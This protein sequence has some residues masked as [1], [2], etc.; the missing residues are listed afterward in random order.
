MKRRDFLRTLGLSC[1]GACCNP[2][3][4]LA[5]GRATLENRAGYKT[6]FAPLR[7]NPLRTSTARITSLDDMTWEPGPLLQQYDERQQWRR[8]L[9][10][11]IFPENKRTSQLVLP[12]SKEKYLA[13]DTFESLPDTLACE[14]TRKH[15]LQF[16]E[17]PFLYPIRQTNKDH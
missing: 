4:V 2:F 16:F 7:L 1:V 12:E 17:P 14:G 8:E 5:A 15:N 6:A 10:L 3:N 11:Q 13:R 9:Y